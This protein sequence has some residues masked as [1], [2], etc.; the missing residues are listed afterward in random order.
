MGFMLFLRVLKRERDRL[1][2]RKKR[3][4]VNL[5]SQENVS[6]SSRWRGK[7]SSTL[8]LRNPLDTEEKEGQCQASENLHEAQSLQS[9]PTFLRKHT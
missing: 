5:R 8:Y 4:V 7:A 3:P 6:R 2:K 1:R 9:L